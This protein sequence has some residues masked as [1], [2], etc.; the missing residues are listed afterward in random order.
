MATY[1]LNL[2]KKA[3]L[4]SDTELASDMPGG[5]DDVLIYKVIGLAD[6]MELLR[7]NSMDDV[8]RLSGGFSNVISGNKN[9]I[10]SVCITNDEEEPDRIPPFPSAFIVT[11]LKID[12]GYILNTRQESGIS[13]MTNIRRLIKEEFGELIHNSFVA[14]GASDIVVFSDCH[15]INLSQRLRCLN[16]EGRSI[17]N[18]STSFLAFLDEAYDK[19]YKGDE[20]QKAEIRF[21]F[22]GS[23]DIEDIKALAHE[24]LG[25]ECRIILSEYMTGTD[26]YSLIVEAPLNKLMHFLGEIINTGR[27]DSQIRSTNEKLAKQI[28]S[29]QSMLLYDV[30]RSYCT[31]TSLMTL[32]ECNE[33]RKS[34]EALSSDVLKRIPSSA[35]NTLCQILRTCYYL[36]NS[37]L[38]AASGMRISRML[39]YA[40]YMIQSADSIS[41]YV[42]HHC[43]RDI[44]YLLPVA[45][46]SDDTLIEVS[47]TMELTSP[48]IKAV[49]AYENMMEDIFNTIASKLRETINEAI[50]PQLMLFTTIGY[51]FNINSCRYFRESKPDGQER[52]L[53]SVNLPNST[54]LTLRKSY[55][56]CLHEITHYIQLHP[57]RKER[58][59]CLLEIVLR[60]MT[61]KYTFINRAIGDRQ[62]STALN[63]VLSR[64]RDRLKDSILPFDLFIAETKKAYQS[65]QNN[66][67]TQ[68]DDYRI[69][70]DVFDAQDMAFLSVFEF[71]VRETKPD[72]VMMY[73]TGMN[74]ADYIEFLYE[75]LREEGLNAGNDDS[76][77]LRMAAILR[78]IKSE[79]IS[80]GGSKE[81][82]NKILTSKMQNADNQK[83]DF[84]KKLRNC[85]NEQW[86]LLEPVVDYLS[87][88]DFKAI[89]KSWEENLNSSGIKC[90]SPF[91]QKDLNAWQEL[92]FI[93]NHWYRGIKSLKNE[94]GFLA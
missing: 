16:D 8:T 75:H 23:P 86:V 43:L 89:F 93:I 10:H 79:S 14:M 69:W 44:S 68:N 18:Y 73:F 56:L 15:S 32:P 29:M 50:L 51:A 5:E 80:D 41:G 71:F 27:P 63:S 92:T 82:I 22:W 30:D 64:M 48:Y 26:D 13:M 45:L 6:N 9:H 61:I 87:S 84:L 37:P 31:E 67:E 1:M 7:V 35:Q 59:N 77:L 34:L 94:G 85:Y 57:T 52:L 91:W 74:A 81:S 66:A 47:D 28:R 36:L 2:Y 76:F 17:F 40:L 42:I 25:E 21:S 53:L 62:T 55:R 78:W 19:A 90:N 46:M 3:E 83:K 60:F 58:N 49:S 12:T 88:C 70:R 72:A 54:M 39:L 33:Y 38:R 65:E 24:S 11:L 20:L 4:L